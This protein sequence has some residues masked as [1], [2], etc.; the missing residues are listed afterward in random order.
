MT[1]SLPYQTVLEKLHCSCTHPARTSGSTLFS[2]DTLC[3]GVAK[4]GV[5]TL[6][7]LSSGLLQGPA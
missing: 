4:C 1:T 7:E 6:Q 5:A 3:E 2:S